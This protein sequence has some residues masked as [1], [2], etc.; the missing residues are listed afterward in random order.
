MPFSSMALR[1]RLR[2]KHL[3]QLALFLIL[4]TVKYLRCS[5]AHGYTPGANKLRGPG[6]VAADRGVEVTKCPSGGN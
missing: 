5:R 4:Y 3:R 2:Y 1:R 6:P